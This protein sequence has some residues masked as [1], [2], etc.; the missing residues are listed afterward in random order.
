MIYVCVHC[1][2][3]KFLREEPSLCCENG[4]CMEIEKYRNPPTYIKDLVQK[5]ENRLSKQFLKFARTINSSCAF[6]SLSCSK[7]KT[8][9]GGGVILN[10]E[11]HQLFGGIN[12]EVINKYIVDFATLNALFDEPTNTFYP[13][14]ISDLDRV[15]IRELTLRVINILKLV[16][17]Y[18]H[19]FKM[20]MERDYSNFT[21]GTIVLSSKASTNQG[22][23]GRYTPFTN[24]KE[25]SILLAN[26]DR[27]SKDDVLIAKDGSKQL[28]RNRN[29]HSMPLRFPLLFPYG[30]HGWSIGIESAENCISKRKSNITPCE[31]YK[32]MIMLNHENDNCLLKFGRLFQE[33]LCWAAI[34]VDDNN[35]HFYRFNQTCFRAEVY[36]NLMDN[37]G[38]ERVGKRLILPP[39]FYGSVRW[40]L[41]QVQNALCAMRR[42]GPPTYFITM[43]T[44]PAWPEIKQ[45][46]SQGM[47]A[48]DRPDIVVR[49]FHLKLNQLLRDIRYGEIFGKVLAITHTIEYQKRGLPHAHIL[50]T[51]QEQDRCH[52]ANDLDNVVCAEIPPGPS[53][54]CNMQE[55]NQRIM[56][57]NL[58]LDQNTHHCINNVCVRNNVCKSGYPKP[59]LTNSYLDPEESYALYR[60]RSPQNGGET[61]EYKGKY[62]DNSMVVPYNPLL[63][64]RYNC[65][66][67]CEYSCSTKSAKYIYKYIHK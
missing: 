55:N 28:I 57:R 46:L 58:I 29:K 7:T 2:S 65:H 24:L 31:F 49:V 53:P 5:S 1:G 56:L 20:M 45:Y 59:F 12:E 25:I 15:Y 11:V 51:I 67:N 54:E 30:T 60:R 26:E 40:H 37:D 64:I 14:N 4:R 34:V 27:E 47:S 6:S 42:Y 13:R 41:T 39:T 18:V 62:V 9:R 21:T 10:G 38:V 61:A 66:I 32:Y 22:H 3:L 23:V 52:S 16:N 44:N 19:D 36:K 8:I 50:V 63:S 35:L 43:T 33:F 48:Q 17:P